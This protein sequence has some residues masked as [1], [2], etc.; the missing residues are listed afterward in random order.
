MKAMKHIKRIA[1]GMVTIAISGCLGI[2]ITNRF[3]DK[4]AN[5]NSSDERLSSIVVE[6]SQMIDP[7]TGTII[8]VSNLKRK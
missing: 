6:R 4:S 5:I 8:Y 2:A 1:V 7:D 3:S